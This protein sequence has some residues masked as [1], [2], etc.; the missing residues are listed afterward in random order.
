[1]PRWTIRGV[2][3]DAIHAV[4][5][6]QSE[7]GAALGEIVSLCIPAGLDEA[8]RQIEEQFREDDALAVLIQEIKV[9]VADMQRAIS[10]L[11][12]ISIDSA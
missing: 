7:T 4:Q 8:R 12:A 11:S 2:C 10:G 3:P 9:S 5:A 1:M 6:V